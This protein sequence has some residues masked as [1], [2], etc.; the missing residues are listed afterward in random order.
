M[1][2]PVT[3][4]ATDNPG[5]GCGRVYPK[6]TQPG[7][8]LACDTIDN[9]EGEDR[10]RKEVRYKQYLVT[11]TDNVNSDGVLALHAVFYGSGFHIQINVASALQKV[12]LSCNF[13]SFIH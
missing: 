13:F 5:E 7:K 11:I 2:H 8:C 9:A 6:K 1:P 10:A 4:C 12:G 3:K